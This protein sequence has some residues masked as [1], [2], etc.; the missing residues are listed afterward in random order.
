MST[1]DADPNTHNT[2]HEVA[3]QARPVVAQAVSRRAVGS[4]LVMLAATGISGLG[5]LTLGSRPALAASGHENWVAEGASIT[6][7][8]GSVN[9]L[10][11]GDTGDAD[12]R[13]HLSWTGLSAGDRDVNFR[14]LVKG[15]GDGD[16]DGWNDGAAGAETSYEELAAAQPGVSVGS[17]SGA[18]D[19]SWNDVFGAAQPVD[20][21]E[22]TEI[23]VSEDFSSDDDGA[24]RERQ[25]SVDIEVWIDG[26]S[27]SNGPDGD[28]LGDRNS[29]TA[30]ITVTNQSASVEVG[31]QGTFELSSDEE[32]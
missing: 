23:N 6:A 16:S 21:D 10:T 3:S 5:V 12:D 1:K 7:H 22:H 32:V 18:D 15:D 13:L 17:A 26:I 29:A 30:T 4:G 11:F 24:T 20:V 27:G 8:D 28:S 2:P 9:D 25:L 31:G 14:I 19:Y